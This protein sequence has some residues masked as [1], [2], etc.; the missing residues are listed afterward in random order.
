MMLT[1]ELHK[2]QDEGLDILLLKL[3]TIKAFDCLGWK[4]LY[5]LLKWIGFGIK[6]IQMLKATNAFASSVML[7]QGQLTNPI[8]LK[9]SVKQGC[10]LSPLLYLVIVD[11]LNKMLICTIDEGRI[12]GV[13]IPKIQDQITHNLFADDT[14]I[15]LEAKRVYVDNLFHIFR[16]LGDTSSLYV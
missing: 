12:K 6:F 14:S 5:L 13:F 4:F 3:D 2:A 11:A 9:C 1:N 16:T 15:I 8:K 7:I 10:P